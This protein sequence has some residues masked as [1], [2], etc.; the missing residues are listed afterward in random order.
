MTYTSLPLHPLARTR[1]HTYQSDRD[2]VSPNELADRYIGAVHNAERQEKQIGDAVLEAAH[3]ER[4]NRHP[5]TN[6]L[7]CEP[8]RRMRGRNMV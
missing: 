1:A 3:R 6:Q 8:D 4:E 5:R 7:A 2:E